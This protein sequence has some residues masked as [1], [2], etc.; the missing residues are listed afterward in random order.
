[1]RAFEEIVTP[2]RG[3]PTEMESVEYG[4]ANPIKEESL[5]LGEACYS[6]KDGRT[7]F[8]HT[9][10]GDPA[11]RQIAHLRTMDKD[12]LKK[13]HPTS[14]YKIDLLLAA[15][16][17]EL[18][19]RL[20]GKLRTSAVPFLE[21]RHFLGAASLQ[22]KQFSSIMKMGWN[23]FVANGYD[24]LPNWN[25]L[26]EDVKQLSAGGHTFDLYMGT[27]GILSLPD[28]DGKSIDIYL[29]D[30]EKRFP[31]AKYLWLIVKG[32]N[33][34]AAFVILN[35]NGVQPMT[36]QTND[37]DD[38][39]QSKCDRMPWLA[40]LTKDNAHTKLARGKVWC[41]DVT[42]LVNKMSDMPAL[43]GNVDLLIRP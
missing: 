28:I 19:E 10:I 36:N 26:H 30:E 9:K 35:S 37:D 33:G 6:V 27:S 7:I 13:T 17:D 38:V 20:R 23:F 4:Y 42:S 29:N 43:N 14:K 41:C 32:D 16:I 8:I 15:R 5:I 39:C 18:N 34:A 3:C 21:P 40:N 12:Y 22:N 2:V 31:V 11:N 25:A 24:S 1:M